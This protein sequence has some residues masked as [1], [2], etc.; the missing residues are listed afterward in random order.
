MGLKDQMFKSHSTNM[1]VCPRSDQHGR[2]CSILEVSLGEK[3]LFVSVTTCLCALLPGC[4]SPQQQGVLLQSPGQLPLSR[5]SATSLAW[6][7][8]NK[9]LPVVR[10]P[11]GALPVFAPEVSQEGFLR[12][13][14]AHFSSW[15]AKSE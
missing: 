14:E 1:F 4:G 12:Y 13:P 3:H 11:E 9:R 10:A 8:A 15:R 6:I 2:G 5:P 7:V